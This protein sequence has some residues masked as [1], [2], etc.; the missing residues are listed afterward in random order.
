MN[1]ALASLEKGARHG[2]N[3]MNHS[4]QNRYVNHGG[5]HIRQAAQLTKHA[6]VRKTLSRREVAVVVDVMRAI[7]TIGHS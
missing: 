3:D 7:V 4:N 5:H 6:I 1:V 2:K